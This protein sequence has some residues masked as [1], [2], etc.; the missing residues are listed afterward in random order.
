MITVPINVHHHNEAHDMTKQER[1]VA[2]L[3]SK[4]KNLADATRRARAE[5][6]E[7]K[8]KLKDDQ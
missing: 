4:V 8:A 1:K 7:A 6:K 5:L 3:T 2:A